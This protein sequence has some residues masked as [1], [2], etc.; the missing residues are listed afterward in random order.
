MR[1]TTQPFATALLVV[2]ALLLSLPAAAAELA[3]VEMPDRATVGD[4]ELVLNG[5]G[6]RKKLFIKVYVAGLYL[7]E[8]TGDADAILAADAPRQL[9]MHFLYKVDQ[10]KICDAWKEGV[11]KNRPDASDVVKRQ[12]DELCGMMEDMGKGES[13]SFTYVPDQGTTVVVKGA[14]KGSLASKAFA[15]ALWSTWIGPEPP[16]EDFKEGLLGQG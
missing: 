15:D 3:G 9:R 12:L 1:R 11:E 14:E 13:M 4:Q 2:V 16:S 7:S 6:L 10:G 8:T 5:Q